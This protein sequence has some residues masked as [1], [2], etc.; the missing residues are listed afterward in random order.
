ME[1]IPTGAGRRVKKFLHHDYH[2]P[3]SEIFAGDWDERHGRWAGITTWEEC[4]A[5]ERGEGS[6]DTMERAGKP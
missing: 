6:R 5:V 2:N 4:L 1:T 3:D